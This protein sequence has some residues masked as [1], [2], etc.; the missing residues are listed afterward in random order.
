MSDDCI[1]CK[2]IGKKI[3]SKILY[4]DEQVI[5][6]LDVYPSAKGHALVLPKNHYQTLLDI[7]DAELKEVVRI[8]QKIGAAAMKATKADGF[9]VVQN[10]MEAAGQVIHHLHFHVIPRFVNDS[11]KMHL[12]SRK[13]EEEELCEWE[14]RIKG[15]L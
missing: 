6:F 4:E 7:P 13:A 10:N 5:S 1:F 9:N 14:K 3:P 11:L 2:I 8:V 15:H 12:G